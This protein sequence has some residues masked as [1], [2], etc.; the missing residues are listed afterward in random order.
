MYSTVF[1][2]TSQLHQKHR[3]A[4]GGAVDT[5]R[6]GR[7]IRGILQGAVQTTV[8]LWYLQRRFAGYWRHFSFPML[9][10]Q[11]SY[12]L[13]LGLAGLIYTL[14]NDAHNYFVSSAFG[15]AA[16]AIYSV[17]VARLPLIGVMRESINAALLSRVSYLQREGGRKEILRLSIQVMRKLA[18]VYWP[19]YALLMVVANEFVLVLYTKRFIYS[20][21]L[22][23]MNLTLLPIHDYG[24]G[25]YPARIRRAPLL[26]ACTPCS[27]GQHFVYSADD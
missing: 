19:L 24:S 13:P 20:V 26:L 4:D 2:I 18:L 27:A 14:Q 17:G 16:F 8:L 15:A 9:R 22:L 1:I 10:V 23:R 5:L 6:R 21:P 12:T 7:V 25:S 3:N 11:L